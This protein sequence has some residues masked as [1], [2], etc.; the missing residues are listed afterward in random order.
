MRATAKTETEKESHSKD[1]AR[2]DKSYSKNR[3]REIRATEI[4][5][6]RR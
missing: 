5:E 6:T 2:G 4:I 1:T 3:D